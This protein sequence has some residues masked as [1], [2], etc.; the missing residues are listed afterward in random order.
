MKRDS[1]SSLQLKCFKIFISH[2]IS[3]A[4]ITT[5]CWIAM[6]KGSILVLFMILEGKLSVFTIEYTCSFYIN[7]L[8]HSEKIIIIWVY[9]HKSTLNFVKCLLWISWDDHVGFFSPLFWQWMIWFCFVEISL[10]FWCNSTWSLCNHLN[11]CWFCLLLLC[12]RLLHIYSQKVFVS[13][14]LFLWYLYL[15]L[16]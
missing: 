9:Y 15:L 6:V 11:C 13:N 16:L 14:Y 8:C 7:T 10:H 5:Q 3:L 2:P 1:F 4:T 12:Q